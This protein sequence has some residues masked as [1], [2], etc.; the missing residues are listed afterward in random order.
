MTMNVHFIIHHFLIYRFQYHYISI[1]FATKH[2]SKLF[3]R[4]LYQLF[5]EHFSKFYSKKWWNQTFRKLFLKKKLFL[6]AF[7]SAV[8]SKDSFHNRRCSKLNVWCIYNTFFSILEENFWF[9][10]HIIYRIACILFK[11]SK[12]PQTRNCKFKFYFLHCRLSQL[13]QFLFT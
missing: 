8:L 11:V 3:P 1:Y 13:F 5:C 2:V 4:T 10:Y 6:P 9:L 7:F 12:L